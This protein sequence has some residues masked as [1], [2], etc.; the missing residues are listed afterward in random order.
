MTS[1]K[2]SKALIEVRKWKAEAWRE[3]AHLPFRE[4][5]RKRL[6]DSSKVAEGLGLR[7]APA[8]QKPP[9]V[10]AETPAQYQ[11]CRR[12]TKTK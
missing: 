6:A 10:F 8:A 12:P 3:V 11:T 9:A 7:Y 5:V 1:M 2:E 4:A